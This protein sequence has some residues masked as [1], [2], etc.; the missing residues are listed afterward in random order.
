MSA[1]YNEFDKYAAQWLRSLIAA[2]HI[3]PGDVDERSITEVQP[4]DLKGYTQCHFFAGIGG[5]S[6]ALRLAGWPDDR[7]VWTGSCPCQPFSAAGK[8]RGSE[9]ERHL[10]PAF[11]RLIRE[12][13][14]AAVFGEQ[15]AGVAGYAWF[16][17]V[18]ADMEGEAYAAAAVDI[19]AHSVGALHRRQ[20]LYWVADYAGERLEGRAGTGVQRGGVQ[21]AFHGYAGTMA[22]D[23]DAGRSEQREHRLRQDGDAQPRIDT[24][25]RG[26]DGGFRCRNIWECFKYGCERAKAGEPPCRSGSS[27]GDAER[28]RLEGHRA[29]QGPSGRI[30]EARQVAEAGALDPWRDLEWLACSDGKARP[31]QPGLFPLAHGVSNRVGRLRAYGNA[32]VPQVAARFIRAQSA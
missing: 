2:G 9:D 20:R 16:D 6:Y 13:R 10:W 14:P 25:G 8:Q 22:H 32:I 29:D 18:A 24:D 12:C 1:Y 7:P 19:G 31:T 5:W 27:T 28:A 3:A 11:F 26:A 17:H 30:G 21:S 23:H 4:D 15:V